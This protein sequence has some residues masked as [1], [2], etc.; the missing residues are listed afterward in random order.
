[1]TGLVVGRT[2]LDVQPCVEALDLLP[3]K[4]GRDDGLEVCSHI[5]EWPDEFPIKP[6]RDWVLDAAGPGVECPLTIIANLVPEQR[7]KKHSDYEYSSRLRVHVPLQTNPGVFF[8]EDGVPTHMEVGRAYGIDPQVP[9]SIYNGGYSNRIHM[10][11][12]LV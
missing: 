2:S 12:V 8:W 11:F 5:F 10:I 7:I 3:W 4:W 6:V 1:M 9:H